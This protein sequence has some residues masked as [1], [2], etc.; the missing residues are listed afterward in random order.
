MHCSKLT[1]F[2][3]YVLPMLVASGVA[4]GPDGWD[5]QW[6]RILH[7]TYYCTPSWTSGTV[8][9]LGAP[10]YNSLCFLILCVNTKLAL[11][12]LWLTAI[13]KGRET[14]QKH[15]LIYSGWNCIH[16]CN[17]TQTHSPNLKNTGLHWAHPDQSRTLC[18]KLPFW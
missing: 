1:Q 11:N 14:E 16:S 7:H 9:K 10:G 8:E 4:V 12:N 5:P 18:F 15:R 13:A 6:H 3:S 2:F 17:K